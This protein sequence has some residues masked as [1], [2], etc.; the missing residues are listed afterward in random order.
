[1][2]APLPANEAER[3]AALRQYQI[4]DSVEEQAFDDIT[5]L[6]SF[7]CETPIALMSLVDSD[8]Q[9]FKSRVG[10]QAKQTP[11]EY[12][13]CAH[14]ILQPEEVLVVNDALQ[15]PRFVDSPLVTVDPRIRFYAGAPLVTA[16]GQALGAL[17]VIDRTPRELPPEKIEAL[18]ALARQVVGQME[19]RRVVAELERSTAELRT[20]QERLEQY[21]RELESANLALQALTVTDSLTGV[22]NRRAFD[23]VLQEELA[24][25]DRQG[26][27][28]SLL[29][30]DIDGFKPYNDEF[31]H[32]AGDQALRDVAALLAAHTRPFDVVARYGGEEFA[33][34]LP[35][36]GEGAALAAGER[37]RC[38]VEAG[39]WS[40]RRLTISVGAATC[41]GDTNATELVAEADRALYRMKQGGRNR[42]GH[43]HRAE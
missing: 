29:L 39:S 38:A 2:R 1:L 24:R 30:I 13:F 23:H 8:R 5:R 37:L 21:Q 25:A 6:A 14:A 18:R 20:Y 19:L 36:T 11:R 9:W 10:I 33:V 31:G 7:I 28:L 34:I 40:E 42:V 12:A 35:N 32:L 26:T 3:L 16:G 27:P 17:C 4:L 41:A 43:A 22:R 15:D